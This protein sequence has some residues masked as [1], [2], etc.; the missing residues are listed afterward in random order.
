MGFPFIEL[1]TTKKKRKNESK[2]KLYNQSRL[3]PLLHLYDYYKT[4]KGPAASWGV[5]CIVHPTRLAPGH[6]WHWKSERCENSFF[7]FNDENKPVGF[8]MRNKTKKWHAANTTKNKRRIEAIDSSLYY[9]HDSRGVGCSPVLHHRT[10]RSND[11]M[12]RAHPPL[13]IHGDE[14]PHPDGIGL[15][16]Y[17]FELVKVRVTPPWGRFISSTQVAL[18]I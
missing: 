14:E 16:A 4:S 6:E 12:S 11:V 9:S 15:I 7:F 13:P 17:L 8:M 2:S 10:K 1:T 3:L 5:F 18:A